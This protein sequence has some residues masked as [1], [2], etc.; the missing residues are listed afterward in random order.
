MWKKAEGKIMACMCMLIAKSINTD[1]P[2]F[3]FLQCENI[4]NLCP[5][6]TLHAYKPELTISRFLIFN[7]HTNGISRSNPYDIL[8]LVYVCETP[9]PFIV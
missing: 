4:I 5:N 2:V 7:Y 6:E 1:D 3:L 8:I 9:L